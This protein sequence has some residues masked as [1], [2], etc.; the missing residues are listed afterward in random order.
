M[1]YCIARKNQFWFCFF[2]LLLVAFVIKIIHNGPPQ[3]IL[4]L[5]LTF[6][7]KSLCSDPCPSGDVRKEEI[8]TSPAW[9]LPPLDILARLMD[10]LLCFLIHKR[11]WHPDPI[12][13]IF[14]DISLYLLSHPTASDSLA[15]NS[16]S[17]IHA[18]NRAS[19]DLVTFWVTH[20]YTTEA[21]LNGILIH[22]STETILVDQCLLFT[23][24]IL[25]ETAATLIIRN[26]LESFF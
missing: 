17:P 22:Q 7:L 11:T 25:E 21:W 18:S 1:W 2:D 5:C 14:W 15:C 8:N 20:V 12:K 19:L 13:W 16:F 26:A 4:P 3:R 10:F 9:G 24:L 6:D 23:V